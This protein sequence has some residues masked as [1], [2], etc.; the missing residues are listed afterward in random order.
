MRLFSKKPFIAFSFILMLSINSLQAMMPF[1]L[2]LAK[3]TNNTKKELR[4]YD[5]PMKDLA[6]IGANT[7]INLSFRFDL[8]LPQG[9]LGVK[10]SSA[11]RFVAECHSRPELPR[12]EVLILCTESTN[13]LRTKLSHTMNLGE[14]GVMTRNLG[15]FVNINLAHI[16]KSQDKAFYFDLALN[17]D[18]F[19]S[20][21]IK[22]RAGYY[23]PPSLLESSLNAVAKSIK[24]GTLTLAQAKNVLPAELREAVEEYSNENQ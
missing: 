24:K 5:Q 23:R 15:E 13:R 4:L 22:I 14:H 21:A 12:L 8:Q 3:V 16:P 18:D 6:I 1:P 19:E 20:S 17:G 7:V 10:G 2:F 11:K 9:P